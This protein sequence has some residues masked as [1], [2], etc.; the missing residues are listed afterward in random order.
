MPKGSRTRKPPLTERDLPAA[1]Q[2]F[3]DFLRMQ[4]VWNQRRLI[5]PYSLSWHIL[6]IDLIKAHPDPLVVSMA[7]LVWE[8]TH[9]V[10]G[11]VPADLVRALS[12]DPMHWAWSSDNVEFF[13][14]MSWR[15]AHMFATTHGA[16]E[17]HPPLKRVLDL[18]ERSYTESFAR[19]EDELRHEAL[20]E[21]AMLKMDVWSEQFRNDRTLA[22]N[23]PESKM[24]VV[25][26]ILDLA[27][28][29]I[30]WTQTS[31]TIKGMLRL[32]NNYNMGYYNRMP[33]C[34]ALIK[35]SLMGGG[36]ADW[37]DRYTSKGNPK[38]R[39]WL[40]SLE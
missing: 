26:Y 1:Y 39:S 30:F 10:S 32:V 35:A 22:R 29:P 38:W 8:S 19:E 20:L 5:K 37:P 28:N 6:V 25:F 24:D 2:V 7:R 33:T 11:V 14:L 27:V 18:I 4:E 12:H 17:R 9:Q 13:Q 16:P 31:S 40:P 23:T 34:E 15:M 36:V 21:E 3:I